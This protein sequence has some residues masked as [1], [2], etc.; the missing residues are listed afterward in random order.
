MNEALEQILRDLESGKRKL[1]SVS[2]PNK[3]GT[4]LT[5]TKIFASLKSRQRAIVDK[6][7]KQDEKQIANANGHKETDSTIRN[8]S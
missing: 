3:I 4:V 1:K 8:R 7:R 6:E 2:M 5:S